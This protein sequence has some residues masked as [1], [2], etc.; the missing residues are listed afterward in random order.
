MSGKLLHLAESSRMQ[1]YY[2]ETA[3]ECTLFERSAELG[4]PLLLKGPT[5]CGKSRFVEAMA[6]RLERELITVP[7]HDDT[8]AAD[9]LGR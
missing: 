4:L 3:D 8:G 5:G 2:R 6:A 7:C 9:L 1:P